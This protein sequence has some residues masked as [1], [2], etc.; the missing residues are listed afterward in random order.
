MISLIAAAALLFLKAGINEVYGRVMSEGAKQLLEKNNVPCTF[1]TLAEKI[2]NRAGTD[3]CPME[4][5]VEN[6]DSPDTAFEALCDT[7][8]RLKARSER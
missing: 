6:I 4:K 1:E 5:T 3:I 8:E 2:I 7:L